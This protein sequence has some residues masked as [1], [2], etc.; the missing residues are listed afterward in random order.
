M[1]SLSALLLFA[2]LPAQVLACT[3]DRGDVQEANLYYEL[4]SSSL[5]MSGDETLRVMAANFI[6]CD[7]IYII[8]TGSSKSQT[9]SRGSHLCRRRACGIRESA[10]YHC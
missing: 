3:Y 8:S 10:L 7:V 9:S 1:R 4:G 2:A 6:G 5:G